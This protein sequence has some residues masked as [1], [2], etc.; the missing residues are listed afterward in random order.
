MIK[1]ETV[2]TPSGKVQRRKALIVSPTL[3]ALPEDQ[4]PSAV[5]ACCSC[6]AGSWNLDEVGLACHCAV[7][8][9]V[10]WVPKQKMLILCDDREA[11]LAET[12]PDK[13]AS[14]AAA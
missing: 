6:P 8:R 7:R 11:A 14:A 9:Y 12:D 13:G 3:L 1:L 10:S 2:S 4:R 5:L